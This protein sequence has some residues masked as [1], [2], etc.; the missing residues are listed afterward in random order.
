MSQKRLTCS[1]QTRETSAECW[2]FSTSSRRL[3]SKCASAGL[4]SRPPVA[5]ID[6]VGSND[7]VGAADRRFVGVGLGAVFDVDAERVRAAAENLQQHCPRRAAE[8]VAADAE[9]RAAEVDRDV[10]PI[11][12]VADDLPVGL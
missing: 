5:R 10:V 6:A 2:V 8:A 11:R 12:E 3:D 1:N 7:Q 4:T 9:L